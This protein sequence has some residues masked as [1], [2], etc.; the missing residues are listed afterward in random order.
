MKRR[1]ARATTVAAEVAPRLLRGTGHAYEG[2]SFIAT[3]PS[4]RRSVPF[5]GRQANKGHRLLR[6]RSERERERVPRNS[7]KPGFSWYYERRRRSKGEKGDI[8]RSPVGGGGEDATGYR[9]A[10]RHSSASNAVECDGLQ[11][12]ITWNVEAPRD[13]DP[14]AVL[15]PKTLLRCPTIE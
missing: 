14:A 8:K 2:Q 1:R 10:P 3:R 9:S 12:A 15:Y 5:N 13:G 7:L 6:P 4:L 11:V